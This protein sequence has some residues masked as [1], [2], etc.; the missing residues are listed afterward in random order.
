MPAEPS[1]AAKENAEALKSADP[2]AVDDLKAA[3]REA[4]GGAEGAGDDYVPSKDTDSGKDLPEG[5]EL[6]PEDEETV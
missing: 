3:D 2:G 4:G 1:L 6:E 5:A